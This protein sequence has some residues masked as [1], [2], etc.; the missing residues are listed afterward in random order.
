VQTGGRVSRF[1]SRM[2][3]LLRSA[4]AELFDQSTPFGRLALV[5]CLQ[6]AGTAFITV[7]LAGSLFFSISPDA[8]KS[9]VLL[10]LLI[11]IAPFAVVG[12]A[13][14]PLLDRGR[15]ARRTS[16][17]IANAGS[18]LACLG[19]AKNLHD[20]LLFPEA[21]VVLVLGKLYLVARAS[22]VPEMIADDEDLA[23]ANAK[24]AVLASLASLIVV[25]IAVGIFKIGPVWV[26]RTGSLIFVAGAIAALRLTRSPAEGERAAADRA[27]V[28][29]A[30]VVSDNSFYDQGMTKDDAATSSR[31]KRERR[32]LG[33]PVYRGEVRAA[34]GALTVARATVGFVEFFLAFALRREHA[35]AWWFGLLLG[36][37]AVGSLVGSLI[38]PR[39]RKFF[40]EQQII[41]IA[42]GTLVVGALGAALV[43]GLLAQ[44][45]L[46]LVVGIAP[47]SAKPAL[48]SIAQ[49][50]VAPALLG[51]AFGRIETRLQ[52]AW[53]AAAL[54][55]VIV[56]FALRVGDLAVAC[57]S[58][59]ALLSYLI[60]PRAPQ[61][62]RK[63]ATTPSG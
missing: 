63:A 59:L 35:A 3:S 40:S 53:V 2:L 45:L 24:L 55:A 28:A 13:L 41:A 39:L 18:A 7:S 48:D 5:H 25:P 9:K 43:G 26:L 56:P 23:S 21:F 17:A 49:R 32:V 50:H 16:V 6:A 4:L 44:A 37:S 62:A 22:L 58:F 46:T 60:A 57:V 29:P 1:F 38:V 15:Q 8:A 20:L 47:T 61:K 12:P 27:P 51:R 52:L 10:Y 33:R 34:A 42:L 31:E 14:S 36:V 19:M 11:T 54:L 30:P